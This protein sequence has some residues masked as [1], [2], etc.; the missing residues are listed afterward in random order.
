LTKREKA[1]KK[2]KKKE[3]TTKRRQ[4]NKNE[5]DLSDSMAIEPET[6]VVQ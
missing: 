2:L 5:E 6:V 1:E 3:K 4:K